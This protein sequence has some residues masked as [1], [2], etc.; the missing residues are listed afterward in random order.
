MVVDLT[1]SCNPNYRLLFDNAPIGVV[2]GCEYAFRQRKTNARKCTWSFYTRGCTAKRQTSSY[3]YRRQFYAIDYLSCAK[4]YIYNKR[5]PTPDGEG[6]AC[7]LSRS[8]CMMVGKQGRCTLEAMS[9]AS[10]RCENA[11]SSN[12]VSLCWTDADV[13]TYMPNSADLERELSKMP[14]SQLTRPGCGC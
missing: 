4:E 1:I 12:R 10:S 11:L 13:K 8:S 6:R 2:N 9:A 7:D 5:R 14:L 3:Q